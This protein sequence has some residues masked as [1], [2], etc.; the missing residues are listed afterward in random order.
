MWLFNV[1]T[2]TLRRI[3]AGGTSGYAR[4]RW[5]T[6]TFRALTI[7]G[8][9]LFTPVHAQTLPGA[10]TPGGALPDIPTT[11]FSAPVITDQMF[12]IPPRG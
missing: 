10:A 4:C 6:L 1:S 9:A 2:P 12:P 3:T 7:L 8:L 11:D 5:W